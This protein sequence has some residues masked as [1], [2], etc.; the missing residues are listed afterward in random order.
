[1]K[2]RVL[3]VSASIG[4]G[5]VAAAKALEDAFAAHPKIDS[6]DI[7]HIDL[8]NFTY[9]GFRRLYRDAYFD[10]VK[11][12]PDF[13][14]W[15][16][17]RLE[18]NHAGRQQRLLSRLSRVTSRRLARYV[19]RTQPDLIIHTHFLAPGLL[20]K[21]NHAHIPQISVITD[22][23]AHSIW[24]HDSIQHYFVAC[25]EIEAHL[26][27]LGVEA[28]KIDVT[29]IPIAQ[30]FKDLPTRSEAQNQV[31]LPDNSILFMASGMKPTTVQ[32]ILLQLRRLDLNT[33]VLVSTGRSPELTKRVEK[34]IEGFSGK[35][36]FSL[37]GF[38]KEL[39]Q[40]MAAANLI[41]GKPGG[42]TTSESLAAGLP[43]AV[44]D[45]YPLQ[46]EANANFL[47]ENGA[48]FRIDPHS[49][50]SYKLERYW[51]NPQKQQQMSQAAIE[52]SKATA[53]NDITEKLLQRYLM[54]GNT[55]S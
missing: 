40:I 43:F 9:V 32:T 33:H 23:G 20:N 27:S 22:Y 26:K 53:A 10:L 12:V 45:P 35:T 17:K 3:I 47:I 46:E 41:I 7:D 6:L 36:T 42:L 38:T 30:A 1:M 54:P 29:G 34:A 39:P 21:A 55:G 2:R 11:N 24:Q 14:D 5:H 4:G 48:G 18:K 8:L 50:F 28:S 44:V 52:L 49:V 31:G 13:V 37:L 51:S 25:H 19:K 15:F 16:G